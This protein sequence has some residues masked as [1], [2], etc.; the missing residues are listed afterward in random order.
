MTETTRKRNDERLTG[1]IIPP[2]KSRTLPPR[3]CT[4]KT[5]NKS[6][7]YNRVS[8]DLNW[9]AVRNIG[10]IIIDLTTRQIE[11]SVWGNGHRHRIIIPS[12]PL[13]PKAYNYNI[14]PYTVNEMQL[15]SRGDL[16]EFAVGSFLYTQYVSIIMFH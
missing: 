8:A 3:S 1:R 11:S 13:R 2:R 14:D 9:R 16:L 7:I 15:P 12:P 4:Y 10:R 5:L 6:C